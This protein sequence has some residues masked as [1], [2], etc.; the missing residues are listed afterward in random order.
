M[1]PLNRLPY[2]ATCVLCLA[3]QAEPLKITVYASRIEDD[4]ADMPVAVQ[5]IDADEI[6][7]SGARDLPELLE[8]KAGLDIHRLNSNPI[9]SEIA[10]R[11]F[12]ENAF[13]RVKVLVDGEEL[14]N[15]DMVAPNLMRPA[16]PTRKTA[17]RFARSR[18]SGCRKSP[19]NRM[20]PSSTSTK[21][22][23]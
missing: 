23:V 20:S 3:T 2:V 4:K 16:M 1:I 8:K 17:R 6:A 22:P 13:G 19:K 12:G 7:A 10:M 5:T 15:V 18:L 14:N 21:S 9:Q 11:G